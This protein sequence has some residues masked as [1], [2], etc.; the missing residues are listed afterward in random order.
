MFILV[1]NPRAIQ[2][3]GCNLLKKL[4]TRMK[5]METGEC[6]GLTHSVA[7]SGD[8]KNADNALKTSE[9]QTKKKFNV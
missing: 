2:I 5:K 9:K 3:T 6:K 4:E 8:E 7:N 1:P